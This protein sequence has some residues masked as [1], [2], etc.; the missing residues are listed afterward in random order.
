MTERITVSQFDLPEDNFNLDR[1]V[2]TS[3]I[4]YQTLLRV[5]KLSELEE[6]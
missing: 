3:S 5:T 2:S 6:K 4:P 1:S